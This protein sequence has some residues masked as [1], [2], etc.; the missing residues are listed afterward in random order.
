[1]VLRLREIS[2]VTGMYVYALIARADDPKIARKPK[3][4]FTRLHSET[5]YTII[6]LVNTNRWPGWLE[7]G[8]REGREGARGSCLD[9]PELNCQT[10]FFCTSELGY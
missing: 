5:P 10:N 7:R 9:K 8:S 6:H 1:M 2:Y 4:Q 3:N